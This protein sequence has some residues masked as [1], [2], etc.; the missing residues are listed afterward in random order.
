[1]IFEQW[2]IVAGDQGRGLF[3]QG[4]Q[5]LVEAEHRVWIIQL[6]RDVDPLGVVGVHQQ[7]GLHICRAEAAV[8]RV[9]P[10]HRRAAAIAGVRADQS[11]RLR[12]WKPRLHGDVVLA[13]R[14][15][16][17]QLRD[18]GE[19]GVAHADFLAVVQE[20]RAAQREHQR[21]REPRQR[22]I[23]NAIA[24]GALDA[25]RIVIAERVAGPGAGR[26]LGEPLRLVLADVGGRERAIRAH[27]WK[28]E[29]QVQLVVP[30]TVVGDV[31]IF[32]D[33]HAVVVLVH[34]L[35]QL[36]HQR[37]H[38]VGAVY[39]MEEERLPLFADRLA[40]FLCLCCLAHL[41]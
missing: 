39:L 32:G 36:L 21:Q 30:V 29:D 35:P 5:P 40:L 23:V 3:A 22:V 24:K 28:V 6:L 41:V 16:V 7:P 11:R 33:Q 31:A 9:S 8:E 25:R 13:Q 38:L 4:Q 26:Q 12:F 37:V 27:Q 19:D 10:L 1:M 18:V 14:Q 34:H 15:G 17:A 20:G 2:C